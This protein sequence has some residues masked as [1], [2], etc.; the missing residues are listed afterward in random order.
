MDRSH[1]PEFTMIELYQAYADY[2]VMMELT[3]SLFRAC[4]RVVSG[5]DAAAPAP[6]LRF[7]EVE[8]D[9]ERP[10][11]VVRYGDLFERVLGFPMTDT[12]RLA[13][14]A[15]R[16]GL[17]AASGGALDPALAVNALFDEAERS[18][19][20]S[21]P[22]FV[23]DYPA[24]LCPLTRQHRD[25]P[26]LAERFELYI[27]G[28]EIANA[29]TELND[30]DVQEERFRAQLAG[31]DDEESTFRTLDHDFLRALKVGMPPAG[32]LGIGIDRLMM[33]MLNQRTIRDVILFPMM[34]PEA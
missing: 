17:A 30:P 5:G 2:R 3:E 16:R 11:E 6:P 4:A 7:G 20:P 24:P 26:A 25:D 1:N 31:I 19:D 33:V 10:F 34:R 9:F 15:A 32:G 27:A 18:I 8:I 29:Y 12:A 23:I 21:R 22:T 14:E 28:M 13:R